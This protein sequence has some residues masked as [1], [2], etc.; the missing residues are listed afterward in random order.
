MQLSQSGIRDFDKPCGLYYKADF[1]H[2]IFGDIM[3][4]GKIS[5]RIRTYMD[6]RGMDLKG[7]AEQTVRI[8]K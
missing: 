1:F 5:Q 7:M 2:A 4:T 3:Q 6:K 8:F